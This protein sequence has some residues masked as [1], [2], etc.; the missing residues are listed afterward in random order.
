MKIDEIIATAESLP[1]EDRVL[2]IDYLLKSLNMPETEIDKQW[3]AVANRRLAE[4]RNGTVKAVPGKEVFA[5]I[6]QKF[7]RRFPRYTHSIRQ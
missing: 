2:L 6:R 3:R 7:N 5:N 1:V 4:L